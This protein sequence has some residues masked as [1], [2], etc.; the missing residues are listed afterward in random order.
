M[1]TTDGY[2][3]DPAIRQP[4]TGAGEAGDGPQLARARDGILADL[5]ALLPDAESI[6]VSL[7]G[8][9]AAVWSGEIWDVQPPSPREIVERYRSGPWASSPSKL[10][11]GLSA[12]GM[13]LAVTW[14]VPLYTLA[15]LSHRFWRAFW[16]ITVLVLIWNYT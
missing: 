15:V 14:S 4:A 7:R 13:V 12:T 9:L 11:R 1:T 10:L 8:F 3:A 16:A 6:R 2:V 5:Q